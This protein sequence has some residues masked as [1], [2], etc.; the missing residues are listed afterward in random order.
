MVKIS[1][2]MKLGIGLIMLSGLIYLVKYLILGDLLN[3]E[4]YIFNALGFLPISVLLVT[5]VINQLL[6][7]RAKRERLEKLN[8]VIGTFYSEVGI[9]L[10]ETF[11]KFDTGI[12][13][14]S[15]KLV[16]KEDWR[17]HEFSQLLD[18]LKSH[19]YTVDISSIDLPTIR[20]FLMGHRDFLLRLLENPALL[21]HGSF[22]ETLRSVFHLNE[23]LAM[24]QNLKGLPDRDKE[25]LRGDI[26]RVYSHVAREWV[27]YMEYLKKHYPYLF[28]LAMR[29]NPF[30]RNASVV[31][32]E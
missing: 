23:E 8:M 10:L 21:E 19:Q 22:T 20:A 30:D 4:Q 31:F 11:S 27:V 9:G 25:H 7:I 5:L 14:M 3:T 29:R 6:S 1:W 32:Q 26:I 24:R 13:S 2:E 12:V 17:D 28:S 15:D 18:L 16:V